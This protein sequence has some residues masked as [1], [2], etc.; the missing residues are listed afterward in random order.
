MNYSNNK[1]RRRSRSRSRSRDRSAQGG[2]DQA[3]HSQQEE[4]NSYQHRNRRDRDRRRARD[5]RYE[6]NNY[7]NNQHRD[8]RGDR[9]YG[10]PQQPI[11][12]PNAAGG[13]QQLMEAPPVWNPFM[14]GAGL[15]GQAPVYPFVANP[16][17]PPIN[18]FQ[19]LQQ[20]R[21]QQ[22]QPFPENEQ[23]D[24]RGRGGWSNSSRHN[25]G[26][27]EMHHRSDFPRSHN[28]DR[29][30]R[31]GGGEDYFHSQEQQR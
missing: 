24:F 15:L 30:S 21:Y 11:P 2:S 28:Q 4:R 20:Q 9:R 16:L 3:R 19:L 25:D 29:V 7:D 12:P 6:R 22:P 26:A 31:G 8:G 23:H 27:R 5:D 17:G 10:M 1:K 13:F 14:F 18:P